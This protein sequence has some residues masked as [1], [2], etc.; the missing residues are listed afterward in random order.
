VRIGELSAEL[1]KAPGA[2][3]HNRKALPTNGKSVKASALKAAG[4]STSAA[5]RAEP[6]TLR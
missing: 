1:E 2:G 6:L 4:I 5:H 3:G